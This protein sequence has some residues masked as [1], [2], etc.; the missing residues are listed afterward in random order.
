MNSQAAAIHIDSPGT[1]L[2]GVVQSVFFTVAGVG[3]LFVLGK[4]INAAGVWSGLPY[5][6]WQLT[7]ARAAA[8]ALVV[9]SMSRFRVGNL[10]LFGVLYGAT[11]LSSHTNWTL[12]GSAALA[13]IVAWLVFTL[14]TARRSPTLLG[15]LLPSLAY[16]LTITLS[17]LI[18]AITA[19]TSRLNLANWSYG[20][21]IRAASTAVI[22]IALWLITRPK[23]KSVRA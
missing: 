11:M 19:S 17:G 2:N 14:F 20:L 18:T 4:C 13:G 8:G 3:T 10:A 1:R 6:C 16:T 7:G 22:V 5:A 12:L 21:G 15:I 23:S 9:G